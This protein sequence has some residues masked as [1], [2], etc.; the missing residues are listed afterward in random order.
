[1]KKN[2]EDLQKYIDALNGK[3]GKVSDSID[4]LKEEFNNEDYEKDNE[5]VRALEDKLDECDK[6]VNGDDAERKAE[7]RALMTDQEERKFDGGRSEKEK[8]LQGR[9]KQIIAAI[10]KMVNLFNE[11]NKLIKESNKVQK[12]ERDMKELIQRNKE[13]Q[14]DC[15]F[16]DEKVND[17]KEFAAIIDKKL[18]M[19]MDP[20]IPKIKEKYADKANLID[21]CDEAFDKADA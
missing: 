21:Q 18:D 7:N 13:I 19:L 15:K 9:K 12:T 20:V 10:N 1:M 11:N 17:G 14:D 4:A 6:D 8:S 2:Y 16:I 5:F 3:I